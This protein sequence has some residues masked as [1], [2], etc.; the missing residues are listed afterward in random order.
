M[1]SVIWRD[2]KKIEV[3]QRVEAAGERKS[4]QQLGEDVVWYAGTCKM[5]DL[6]TANPRQN[7]GMGCWE[8]Q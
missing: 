7:V 5:V 1:L 8:N 4:R 2:G 3:A 6:A